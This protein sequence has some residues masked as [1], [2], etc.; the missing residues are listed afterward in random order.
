MAAF[1]PRPFAAPQCSACTRRISALGLEAWHT[2]RQ[3]IRGKK[4]LA[5]GASV[6]TVRLMRDKK[7]FGRKGSIVPISGG[8][9]RNDWFPRGIAEYLTQVEIKDLRLK[10]VPIERDYAFISTKHS[11]Q[12]REERLQQE[13]EERRKTEEKAL[14]DR[15]EAI[16]KGQHVDV[17]RLTPKRAT[18]LISILVPNRLDFYRTKIEQDSQTSNKEA[19]AEGGS[20]LA[21]AFLAAKQQLQST[22]PDT[23][24]GSVSLGDVLSSI[25]A[26]LSN[27]DEA[28]RVTLSEED[29]SFVGEVGDGSRQVIKRLGEFTVSIR[30]KGASEPIFRTIRVVEQKQ[31]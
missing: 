8:R 5:N 7:G 22:H 21:E 3:Q 24:Y 13:D 16:A 2:S 19:P 28:S 17:E 25:R 4:R 14:E 27:N 26:V 31:Q 10:S 9:M 20:G 23:I 1:W 15:M 18:E 12:Q 29:L 6:M 11:E 30:T